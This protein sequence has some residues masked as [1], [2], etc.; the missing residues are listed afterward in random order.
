MDANDFRPAT[1]VALKD[2][3]DGISR[4]AVERSLAQP[5]KSIFNPAVVCGLTDAQ[6]QAI[7]G[8]SPDLMAERKFNKEKLR[9]LEAGLVQLKG[10]GKHRR[11]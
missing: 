10:L 8:E 2:F 3:I 9:V 4:L 7:A 5:I 1:Q 11:Q 6:V